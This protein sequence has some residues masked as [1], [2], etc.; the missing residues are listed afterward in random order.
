[1]KILVT[2]GAG[3][4]GS[5][6]AEALVRK[7][8][9]VRVLDN[10]SAGRRQNLRA[11][12]DDVEFMR[13]RLRRP[14][15]GAA[16]RPRHRRRLPRGGGAQRGALGGRSRP[17]PPRQRHGHPDHARGRARR[18]ACGASS[19]RA[20]RRSTATRKQLPKR[21]DMKPRPLS[22][23]AVGKLIGEHYLRVFAQPLRPGDADPAL[24]QRLRPAP[25][26]GLALQRGDQPLRDRAAGRAAARDLRRRAAEPRLH[27]RRQRRRTGNLR[28]LTAR[29]LAG[30][31]VNVA[32][33]HRVTLR[34]A[35]GHARARDRRGRARG[36]ASFRAPATSATAWPTSPPPSACSAIG[37]RSTSRR[38]CGGRSTGIAERR[39][40]VR[41]RRRAE[42]LQGVLPA[43]L[44][45]RIAEG[46][47]DGQRFFRG[48]AVAERGQQPHD[49]RLAARAQDV[50]DGGEALRVGERRPGRAAAIGRGL[51]ASAAAR[52]GPAVP[53]PPPPRPRGSGS[54]P[55]SHCA[56]PS[57]SQVGQLPPVRARDERMRELVA[58]HGHQ[59]RRRAAPGRARARG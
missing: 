10:L 54:P 42:A 24:L 52:G 17:L 31:S 29:G 4:I 55:S 1:M 23:Y 20:R 6:L 16:R 7:G 39:K 53:P 51:P 11:V 33:G 48:Q 5:H 27:L 19:T 40:R 28:A 25:G 58:Q 21:E 26:R 15:G 56:M 49:R 44:E 8:H 13:G 9:R 43:L 47:G 46:E 34:A 2:G 12:R 45:L 18:A 59:G 38:A 50:G 35:P 3:F 30:Q 57:C 14:R 36:D 41:A 22:P 32:T 37:R